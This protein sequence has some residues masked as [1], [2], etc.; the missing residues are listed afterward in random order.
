[1]FPDQLLQL[2]NSA[3]KP[4]E[5]DAC[6]FSSGCSLCRRADVM[7]RAPCSSGVSFFG[8]PME[9]HQKAP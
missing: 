7:L 8:T 1:M 5:S 9:E 2:K 3:G 6:S 4:E